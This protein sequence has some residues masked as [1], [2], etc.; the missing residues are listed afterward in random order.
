MRR[1]IAVALAACLL[2]GCSS[3]S[4]VRTVDAP[5]ERVDGRFLCDSG[6][7]SFET[8]V[9]THTGVTYLVWKSGVGG[10]S[11]GGITVL[12]DRDGKPVMSEEVSE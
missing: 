7:Y 5:R 10:R 4:I 8:V 12:L 3:N 1:M 11:K 9:D 2:Y 6:N